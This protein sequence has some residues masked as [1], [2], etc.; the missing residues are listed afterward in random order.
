MTLCPSDS[1]DSFAAVWNE[2]LP[3]GNYTRDNVTHRHLKSVLTR[4]ASPLLPVT[5]IAVHIRRGD[6]LTFFKLD[7]N[8]AYLH[9]AMDFYR[10]KY[11]NVRFLIASDDKNYVRTHLAN[12]SDVFITPDSFFSGDDL[13]TLALCEHTIVT[14]GSYGWWAAWLAG[15]NVVHDLQYPSPSSFTSSTAPTQRDV[16][17]MLNGG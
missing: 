11:V 6:F 3:F 16:P 12:N 8:L 17:R 1:H 2:P 13:A 10:R 14:A 15:G 7:T 5:W 9:I 4:P